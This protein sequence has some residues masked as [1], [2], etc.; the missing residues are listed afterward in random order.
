MG[1]ISESETTIRGIVELGGLYD[2]NYVFSTAEKKKEEVEKEK[3]DL[4]PLLLNLYKYLALPLYNEK[5]I[6]KVMTNSIPNILNLDLLRDSRDTLLT[7]LAYFS[8]KELE[9]LVRTSVHIYFYFIYLFYKIVTPVKTLI[10]PKLS[11]SSHSTLSLDICCSFASL[12]SA[13]NP[14]LAA[15]FISGISSLLVSF[16][17]GTLTD[18]TNSYRFFFF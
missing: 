3:H 17:P 5:N 12:T 9:N 10:S 2:P 15:A 18:S 4:M 13:T 11:G 16:S 14:A 6:S 1:N 8:R 7:K